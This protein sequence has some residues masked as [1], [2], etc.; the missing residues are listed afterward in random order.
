MWKR[1]MLPIHYRVFLNIKIA[2]YTKIMTE[3]FSVRLFAVFTESVMPATL[4]I[5]ETPFNKLL[6]RMNDVKDPNVI[7]DLETQR[8]PNKYE[9]TQ[10]KFIQYRQRIR[11]GW[12]QE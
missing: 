2:Y 6:G 4:P 9:I 3:W 12:N 11:L 1:T 5:L 7:N 10:H 8:S